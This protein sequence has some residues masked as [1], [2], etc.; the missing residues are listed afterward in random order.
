MDNKDSS[1]SWRGL[2]DEFR[3]E[4]VISEKE[5]Q[6][7]KQA[8]YGGGSPGQC[9]L[10]CLIANNE[11]VDAEKFI[12][13]AKDLYRYDIA[14][15]IEEFSIKDL[16]KLDEKQ[17]EDIGQLMDINGRGIKGWEFFAE[18]YGYA[19]EDREKFKKA[20]VSPNE[21]S[22]TK[23]LLSDVTEERPNYPLKELSEML[24]NINRF[25]AKEVIDNF[26]KK[27]KETQNIPN[28]GSQPPPPSPQIHRRSPKSPAADTHP[29][30]Y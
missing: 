21:W 9:F 12:K 19:Y 7:Y 3:K 29:H 22:P 8:N 4:K 14:E 11:T 1:S 24:K 16:K 17:L 13:I 15:K 25:D 27:K 30:P 2:Y 23:C 10:K 18:K 26:I 28:C 20:T 5:L 6:K